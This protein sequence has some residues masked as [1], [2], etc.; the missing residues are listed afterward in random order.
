[1]E[2]KPIYIIAIIVAV[3]AVTGGAV[4]LGDN[5]DSGNDEP[6]EPRD[7]TI[8]DSLGNEITVTAP[9]TK[10]CTVNTN[11]AEF[12]VMLGVE[13]RIVGAD[14]TTV[15]DLGYIYDDVVN[16]GDYKTPSGE[17]IVST[18]AKYVI[19]QSS[20]RSLSADTE[21]ALKDNYGIT[22]LRLDFYGE[23]M[24]RDAQ[25]LLK[26]LI[27]DDANDEFNDYK[28]TYDSVVSTVN[29][30][31][32]SATADDSFLIYTPSM[33]AYYNDNSELGKIVKSIHGHNAL[34]DIGDSPGK[35][36]TSKPSAEK[37]YELDQS[38]GL[39]FLFIRGTGAADAVTDYDAFKSTGSAYPNFAE[40]VLASKHVYVINTDVVSGPRDYIGYV[41]FA[42][43]FGIDTGLDYEKLV[44]DFNEDNGFN[45]KYNFVMA[46]FPSS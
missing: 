18:E 36:V 7:V 42:E 19:S 35:K 43:A 41:C 31:A 17:L 11:A 8:T 13:D 21:Q 33:G 3:I 46:Q 45:T 26:I 44:N 16:I 23:N 5:S 28:T 24:M 15:E 29:A 22:V 39:G 20:S 1:M 37:I 10:F 2:F 34:N 12:F 25:E 40:K 38:G 27:D 32:A 9:I 30:K 4:L 14:S 6:V